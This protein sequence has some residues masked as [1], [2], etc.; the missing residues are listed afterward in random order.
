MEE[1]NELLGYLKANH[2][3]QSKVA[4]AI[5]RSMSATNRKINHHADFSQ[6]EIRKL[7]YDLKIPLEML[8]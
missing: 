1:P 8:I 6:S 7:H 3:P 5:G 4:E 2:I